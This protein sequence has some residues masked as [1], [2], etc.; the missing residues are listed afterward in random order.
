M[1]VVIVEPILSPYNKARFVELAKYPDIELHVIIGSDTSLDRTGWKFENI[2]GCN[3]HLLKSVEHR[4]YNRHYKSGYNIANSHQFIMGLRKEINKIKPDYV[5]VHN[6]VQIFQLYF[7]RTYKLGV[8]VEDTLRAEE[9]RKKINR[10]V[11]RCLL[12]KTDFCVP[13]SNDAK[14]F[15]EKNEIKKPLIKSSWSIDL[16][17]FRDVKDIEAEKKKLGIQ[18]EKRTYLIVAALIPRKGLRQF[19]EAWKSMKS[20]FI[21]NNELIIL[22]DGPM[23]DELNKLIYNENIYLLGNKDYNTVSHYMQCSDVFVL[24]TLEDLCSLSVFEAMAAGLPVMTTIYNGARYMV[25]DGV[26]GYVFDSEKKESIINALKKMDTSNIEVMS[27]KSIDK[28]S[29][30]NNHD[31]MFEFM[32]DV[33]NYYEK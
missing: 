26:N 22:G 13:F 32:K 3:M 11:K 19:I 25:E 33:I 15:L 14:N 16:A 31:V 29:K 4:F 6:S 27:K 9:G 21:E 28:I 10:I 17:F 12:N 18:R 8:I 2:D 7:K 20:D 24:P 23:A 30:Y 5:I 1:R